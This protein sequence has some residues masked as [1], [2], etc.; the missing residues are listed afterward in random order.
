MSHYDRALYVL[1][2]G[3]HDLEKGIAPS[4]H[5]LLPVFVAILSFNF[6]PDRL[7]LLLPILR[8]VIVKEPSP[9][10]LRQVLDISEALGELVPV[11]V[12]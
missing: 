4:L 3:G 5:P 9:V 6:F 12:N 1:D 8:N 7:H 10:V 2:P 11:W